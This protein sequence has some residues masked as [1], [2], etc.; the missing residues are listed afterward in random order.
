MLRPPHGARPLPVVRHKASPDWTADLPCSSM[1]EAVGSVQRRRPRLRT[2]AANCSRS[3]PCSR[4]WGIARQLQLRAVQPECVE[5]LDEELLLLLVAEVRH[6]SAELNLFKPQRIGGKIG[7][8]RQIPSHPCT[9]PARP[10]QPPEHVHPDTTRL[11]RKGARM[12]VTD[13]QRARHEAR[14]GGSKRVHAACPRSRRA[15]SALAQSW[16]T[17]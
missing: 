14:D 11:T 13:T 16:A 9:R 8:R 17:R 1:A 2:T 6:V 3:R 7:R 12:Q 5:Q 15:C 10:I 4:A